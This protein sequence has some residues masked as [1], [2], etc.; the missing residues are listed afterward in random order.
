[1]R[2][3]PSAPRT[4]YI[5]IGCLRASESKVQH[6]GSACR[7]DAN[8]RNRRQMLP[9][10]HRHEMYQL[11]LFVSASSSSDELSRS[12]NGLARLVGTAAAASSRKAVYSSKLANFLLHPKTRVVLI[13]AHNLLQKRHAILVHYL[14]TFYGL[15]MPE[16]F[17]RTA[18]RESGCGFSYI[19]ILDACPLCDY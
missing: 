7:A 17:H 11:H 18:F 8:A 14:K 10:V 16:R 3:L 5:S 1:M 4:P 12:S 9:T 2:L 15:V 19:W 6:V 13:F